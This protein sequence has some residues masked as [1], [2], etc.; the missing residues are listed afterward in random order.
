MPAK[1]PVIV[2]AWG[3]YESPGRYHRLEQEIHLTD[4]KTGART[5]H[6]SPSAV[7]VLEALP[8]KPRARAGRW[9]SA[10]T[11]TASS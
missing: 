1:P 10:P 4:G 8:R 7:R 6:V 2:P 9:R 3:K 5:V 11:A